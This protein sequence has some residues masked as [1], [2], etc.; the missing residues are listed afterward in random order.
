MSNLF[1]HL[2]G[3]VAEI[4]K[5]TPVILPKFYKFQPDI[6]YALFWVSSMA[7]NK[8]IKRKLY[9]TDIKEIAKRAFRGCF[10]FSLRTTENPR[11]VGIFSTGEKGEVLSEPPHCT[12]K[13]RRPMSCGVEPVGDRL[14]TKIMD[15]GRKC[16]PGSA[17]AALARLGPPPSS[18][19]SGALPL[20]ACVL[21]PVHARLKARIAIYF[22]ACATKLLRRAS[23][24][25]HVALFL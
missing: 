4:H 17:L 11:R 6:L 15:F 21:L 25:F 18:G 7:N 3:P 20:P 19:T 16:G 22:V 9:T 23:V 10:M 1:R 12:K 13:R 24:T 5:P 8:V 14:S 2:P